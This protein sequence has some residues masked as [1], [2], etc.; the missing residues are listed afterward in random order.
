MSRSAALS[1]KREEKMAFQEKLKGER[2]GAALSCAILGGKRINVRE[3]LRRRM[4]QRMVAR[5]DRR[6]AETVMRGKQ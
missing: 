5:R 3:V 2:F 4:M 6:M 1:A